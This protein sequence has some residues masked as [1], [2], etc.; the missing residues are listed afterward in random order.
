MN[1]KHL[2]YLSAIFLLL[3]R[4]W[5]ITWPVYL[6]DVGLYYD[7]AMNAQWKGLR[8]YQDFPFAYP[9]LT[10]L[11]V[12]WPA[13]IGPRLEMEGFR[14]F[15]QLF[16][17]VLEFATIGVLLRH[18]FKSGF[19]FGKL[20][21]FLT[22]YTVLTTCMGDLIYDRVDFFMT[23][24]VIFIFIYWNERNLIPWT[25]AI[26]AGFSI[27]MLPLGFW[28]F[29]INDHKSSKRKLVLFAL[30]PV[31]SIFSLFAINQMIYPGMIEA[32]SAHAKRGIQIESLWATPFLLSNFLG[33]MS[34][35]IETLYGAQEIAPTVIPVWLLTVSKYFGFAVAGFIWLKH[36]VSNRQE[37]DIYSK[38]LLFLIV[39]LVFLCFQ[40]VLS[41]QFLLW[42]APFLAIY[43]AERWS[44]RIAILSAAI[45]GLTYICFAQGYFK[46]VAYDPTYTSLL[47]LRNIL[48]LVL[49]ILMAKEYFRK[50]KS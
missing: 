25:A 26:F 36:F 12:K 27:K 46:I 24:A 11:L 42:I 1:Q 48:L 34:V 41:T 4:C 32:L 40:R 30:I 6:S 14:F 39:I 31:F 33:W 47:A 2:F 18:L 50:I 21:C 23:A 9:W 37:R 38:N 20:A 44:T 7:L 29:K 35:K 5:I 3:S 8:I 10:W 17:A 28:A 13:V 45:Y 16:C 43:L 19:S 15:L 22:S 49:F